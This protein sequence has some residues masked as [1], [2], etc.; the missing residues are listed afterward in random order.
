MSDAYSSSLEIRLSDGPGAPPGP[1]VLTG[2]LEPDEQPR[3]WAALALVNADLAATRPDRAPLELR[4]Y[5]WSDGGRQIKV[6]TADGE[7]YGPAVWQRGWSGDAA[8]LLADP[9]E[10]LALVADA[11]QQTVLESGRQVWPLCPAHALGLHASGVAGSWHCSAGGGHV[12]A[13][14]GGPARG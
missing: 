2:P 1:E 9:L 7:S 11:A 13:P 10:L 12:V 3:L 14:V 8:E 6:A 4:R 5:D